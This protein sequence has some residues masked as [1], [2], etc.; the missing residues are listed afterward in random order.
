ME[1]S[2]KISAWEH[3]LNKCEKKCTELKAENERLREAL[4]E[5]M[6][7]TVLFD[8]RPA[9]KNIQKKIEALKGKE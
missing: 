1:S 7:Y 9:I 2:N 5:I 8:P 4:D 3:M 6:E